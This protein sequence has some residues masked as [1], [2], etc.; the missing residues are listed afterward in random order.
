MFNL[1]YNSHFHNFTALVI[2]ADISAAQLSHFSPEK[3]NFHR[4]IIR[5]TV[6]LSLACVV[7]VIATAAFYFILLNSSL[8]VHNKMVKRILKAPLVFHALNPVGRIMNRFSQDINSLDD[9]L[10]GNSF[11]FLLAC[12]RTMASLLFISVNHYLVIPL[13]LF[14]LVIFY[15]LTR[16]YCRSAM[17]IKRLMSISCGPLYSHF[18]N[19]MN[20]VKTIRA[21]QR[22]KQ[23]MEKLYR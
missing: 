14:L 7:L 6:I 18:S 8:V 19:T 9:L 13:V 17:D 21:Y 20:G 3:P 1:C 15:F 23:F 16:F 4:A 22:K 10:P 11:Q 5:Y 12:L 2:M